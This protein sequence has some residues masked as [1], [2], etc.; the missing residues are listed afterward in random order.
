MPVPP[1]PVAPRYR[2]PVRLIV[3]LGDIN[4]NRPAITDRC[5]WLIPTSFTRDFGGSSL[6]SID[7]RID[8]FKCNKR[9]QDTYLPVGLNR[10]VEV[11][12]EN[13]TNG[14]LDQ[15]LAWGNVARQPQSI[16]ESESVGIVARF[17]P[18]LFGS[19]F[20]GYPVRDPNTGAIVSVRK[21]LTFNPVIDDQRLPN[22]SDK[23]GS[24]GST[25]IGFWN[26]DTNSPPL[27]S[28]VG[29][30]GEHVTVT[31]AGNTTL[32]GLTDHRVGDVLIFDG[33]R[34]QPGIDPAR[35]VIDPESLRTRASRQL[36]DVI[37]SRWDLATATERLCWTLNRRQRH[38]KNPTL[39]ELQ[40]VL[41]TDT[42]LLENHSISFGA[43][44]PDAL[45]QLLNPFGF[46][47][48]VKHTVDTSDPDLPL[49]ST[50]KV[51]ERGRGDKVT[52]RLQRLGDTI[53]SSKTNC[54]QFTASYDPVKRPNV[55]VGHTALALREGTFP[56]RPAWPRADDKL[57]KADLTEEYKEHDRE[58]IDVY[59]KFVFDTAGDYVGLRD[60]F[61]EAH[62]LEPLFDRTTVPMR[63]RFR[64]A[65]S[66]GL[67]R[68]PVGV[69]GY[70]LEWHNGT[71]WVTAPWSFSVLQHEAGIMLERGVAEEFRSE[72]LKKSRSVAAGQVPAP[73][74]RLTC[75]LEGDRGT[76]YTAARQSTSANGNDNPA[77]YDLSHKFA[78]SRVF[79]SSPFASVLYADRHEAISA[80]TLSSSQL[81]VSADLSSRLKE[82]DRVN[83]LN[84]THNDGVY[85]VASVAYAAPFTTITLR[86]PLVSDAVIDG[87]LGYLTEEQAP[88]TKLKV[89]CDDI[90]ADESRTEINA[91]A[92]LF[93][94]DHPEYE[95]AQVVTK[96][97]TRNLSLDSYHWSA[98]EQLHP[99]ISRMTYRVDGTQMLELT[100]D[101][102]D[103]R[104]DRKRQRQRTR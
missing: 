48:F 4:G 19:R 67:D 26:A 64:P 16:S 34:W 102:F 72:F 35:L 71:A 96:V 43:T 103:Q 60:D 75:C 5:D 76:T 11:R 13:P 62:D 45:D 88:L 59:A 40:A 44:L 28:G 3:L 53:D 93:G 81:Q 33:E 9:L 98:V 20:E 78:D 94:I 63:R 73:I 83:V 10:L 86:E 30:P 27:A 68:R 66:Q 69:N 52:L 55:I 22:R 58:H 46:T 90:Q 74:L 25:G 51:A 89:Y 6:D 47:H 80:Y 77:L 97:E 18:F 61:V 8:L 49:F 37:A 29:N 12:V 57:T 14:D 21:T 42:P 1:P 99:Q 36:H 91:T 54:D 50:I 84:S 56:L 23:T 70:L 32:D 31:T 41:G 100:L 15:V 101:Q 79:S 24:E 85:T 17:D 2:K 82:G 95:L 38:F 65:L 104:S 7:F 39:A 87:I 92:T